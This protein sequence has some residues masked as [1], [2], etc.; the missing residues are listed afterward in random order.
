MKHQPRSM[1]LATHAE[2]TVGLFRNYNCSWVG[3]LFFGSAQPPVDVGQQQFVGHVFIRQ[4]LLNISSAV[5]GIRLYFRLSDSMYHAG[6]D[7]AVRP[8]TD[9]G[10]RAREIRR[11]RR[12]RRP[13][14]LPSQMLRASGL[15]RSSASFGRPGDMS[16]SSARKTEV[17]WPVGLSA[18]RNLAPRNSAATCGANPAFFIAAGNTTKGRP[19]DRSRPSTASRRYGSSSDVRV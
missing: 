8:G 4:H 11:R 12:T 1:R 14:R 7:P 6:S 18:A 15:T 5:F 3:R 16:R 13:R 9:E 2:P 10:R 19:N 17:A